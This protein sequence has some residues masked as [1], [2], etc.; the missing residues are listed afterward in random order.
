MSSAEF[1]AKVAERQAAARQ[2]VGGAGAGARQGVGSA[3]AGASA[4]GAK[5]KGNDSWMDESSDEELVL[6]P[7]PPP[8]SGFDAMR[9]KY[10]LSLPPAP[11]PLPSLSPSLPLS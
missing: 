3:G 10:V 8:K 2:G 9:A 4:A 11:P 7:T 6:E 5:A 1:K